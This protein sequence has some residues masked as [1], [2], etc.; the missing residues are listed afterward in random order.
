MGSGIFVLSQPGQPAT[1]ARNT[2]N[3]NGRYG[4]EARNV[5]DGG[6][7]RAQGNAFSLQCLGVVC[8]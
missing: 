1:V 3:F 7:N 2:A 5:I 6:G 4:I 8:K